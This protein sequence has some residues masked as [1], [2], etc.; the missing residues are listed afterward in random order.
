[1]PAGYFTKSTRSNGDFIQTIDGLPGPIASWILHEIKVTGT[2]TDEN[3]KPI[4]ELLDLWWRNPNDV[5]A[6]LIGNPEFKNDMV[7]QPENKYVDVDGKP[8]EEIVDDIPSA[9]WM[10]ELQVR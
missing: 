8:T 2:L 10:W 9:K 5:V 6:D 1:M 3:G 4:V 7:Y